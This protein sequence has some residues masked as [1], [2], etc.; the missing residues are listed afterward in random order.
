MRSPEHIQR[1]ARLE[2]EFADRLVAFYASRGR[3]RISLW[4]ELGPLYKVDQVVVLND[5]RIGAVEQVSQATEAGFT[6]KVRRETQS[7]GLLVSGWTDESDLTPYSGSKV[8]KARTPKTV[9]PSDKSNKAQMHQ[10][11][12]AWETEKP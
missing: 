11:L 4:N 5:G 6:Y 3:A 1:L 9:Q 2:S 7:G 10:A 8:I 12:L